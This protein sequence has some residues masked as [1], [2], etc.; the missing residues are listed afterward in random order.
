MS[1]D[2]HGTEPIRKDDSASTTEPKTSMGT[3]G[4]KVKN[5]VY[6]P[7]SNTTG[8]M[9]VDP[10]KS[11][12]KPQGANMQGSYN[13]KSPGTGT[14]RRGPAPSPDN[15]KIINGEYWHKHAGYPKSATTAAQGKLH[16]ASQKHHDEHNR[17]ITQ[18][19]HLNA[20]LGKDGLAGAPPLSAKDTIASAAGSVKRNIGSIAGTMALAGMDSFSGA[21]DS[22]FALNDALLSGKPLSIAG[23]LVGESVSR[24]SSI[25]TDYADARE[26]YRI[27]EDAPENVI[28]QTVLGRA[29]Q[30]ERESMNEAYGRE[31]RSTNSMLDVSNASNM[32]VTTGGRETAFKDTDY[33]KNNVSVGPEDWDEYARQVLKAKEDFVA[34]NG[35]DAWNDSMYKALENMTPDNASLFAG[36]MDRRMRDVDRAFN[37]L[38][39]NNR[40]YDLTDDGTGIDFSR[41]RDASTLSRGELDRYK[42]SL[43][44]AR[45]MSEE[46]L[47]TLRSRSKD[48]MVQ[49]RRQYTMERQAEQ[50]YN[51]RVKRLQEANTANNIMYGNADMRV[52]AEDIGLDADVDSRG[53][54]NSIQS[55]ERGIANMTSIL[56][57]QDLAISNAM[58]DGADMTDAIG[59]KLKYGIYSAKELDDLKNRIIPDWMDK[60]DRL[61]QGNADLKEEEARRNRAGMSPAEVLM[62][63]YDINPDTGLPNTVNSLQHYGEDLARNIGAWNKKNGITS[64]FLHDEAVKRIGTLVDP[65]KDPPEDVYAKLSS[66]PTNSP[67]YD[68]MMNLIRS[69][70]LPAGST[71]DT[72][73]FCGMHNMALATRMEQMLTNLQK[74]YNRSRSKGGAKMGSTEFDACMEELQ[75]QKNELTASCRALS[76]PS[77]SADPEK[78]GRTGLYNPALQQKLFDNI[79]RLAR[80]V[81]GK[82]SVTSSDLRSEDGAFYDDDVDS[83]QNYVY[84]TIRE[85]L[86]DPE[87]RERFKHGYPTDQLLMSLTDSTK[88]PE[89][90]RHIRNMMH[91]MSPVGV[92]D[93]D[94]MV[95]RYLAL[96]SLS[97]GRSSPYG[98][99]SEGTD[100]NISRLNHNLGKELEAY[101]M[102]VQSRGYDVTPAL[103]KKDALATAME[104]H[105][106]YVAKKLTIAE[107]RRDR[108]MSD[109]MR[110]ALDEYDADADESI[111]GLTNMTYNDVTGQF[112]MSRGGSLTRAAY[113]ADYYDPAVLKGY[114]DLTNASEPVRSTELGQRVSDLK[115]ELV[116]RAGYL[117]DAKTVASAVGSVTPDMV[118]SM[119]RIYPGAKGVTDQTFKDFF[120]DGAGIGADRFGFS[121]DNGMDQL[122]TM[123]LRDVA[124][125]TRFSELIDNTTARR[126]DYMIRKMDDKKEEYATSKD[127]TEEEKMAF[128][129]SCS[130]CQNIMSAAKWYRQACREIDESDIAMDPDKRVEFMGLMR[131]SFI[132][133]LQTTKQKMWTAEGDT[134]ITALKFGNMDKINSSSIA[135]QAFI[136]AVFGLNSRDES[137]SNPYT[138]A[139]MDYIGDYVRNEALIKKAGNPI[140]VLRNLFNQGEWAMSGRMETPGG[141]SREVDLAVFTMDSGLCNA[142][143]GHKMEELKDLRDKISDTQA[144]ISDPAT[145]PNDLPFLEQDNEAYRNLSATWAAEMAMP[146]EE[147]LILRGLANGGRS[148]AEGSIDQDLQSGMQGADFDVS[149]WAND[150]PE[151]YNYDKDDIT[152]AVSYQ[153]SGEGDERTFSRIICPVVKVRDASG[154]VGRYILYSEN[155]ADNTTRRIA[156]TL[157]IGRGDIRGMSGRAREPSTLRSDRYVVPSVPFKNSESS[158]SKSKPTTSDPS[159]YMRNG[160]RD[161]YEA[162]NA[163]VAGGTVLNGLLYPCGKVG[164]SMCYLVNRTLDSV[165]ING[166][167][168]TYVSRR[169]G[170]IR[171]DRLK[172]TLGGERVYV[173]LPWMDV[174]VKP[175]CMFFGLLDVYVPWA[176]DGFDDPRVQSESL[177]I[178]ASFDEA[179]SA[180]ALIRDFGGFDDT[181][182]IEGDPIAR[183]IRNVLMRAYA[184]VGAYSRTV[185]SQIRSKASGMPKLNLDNYYAILEAS[186]EL[187]KDVGI[188]ECSSHGAW[189]LIKGLK[190]NAMLALASNPYLQYLEQFKS[191][192]P[193]IDAMAY[194]GNGLGAE[195]REMHVKDMMLLIGFIK[196]CR[197][198]REL[199]MVPKFYEDVDDEWKDAA[200]YWYDILHHEG[201]EPATQL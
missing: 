151:L 97:S 41:F 6:D 67:E 126:L 175:P 186:A 134:P 102:Y 30:G 82:E 60:R 17:D 117:N 169:F 148:F 123:T 80:G 177:K 153:A 111:M 173:T 64:D 136:G 44:I 200:G 5:L 9:S 18:T 46:Q 14:G 160:I 4:S 172:Q 125:V 190:S 105:M 114:S 119:M 50:E 192:R 68:M 185:F 57:G 122:V 1:D 63:N 163:D 174:Y 35:Q 165:M 24:L 53:M 66:V 51:R 188:G 157:G 161:L 90:E 34:D 179:A 29:Y 56:N 108:D 55:L 65:K 19:L 199:F 45:K 7:V 150:V 109:G 171:C 116:S 21:L 70:S 187:A 33:W 49:N 76:E 11:S 37:E 22:V 74:D 16:R 149:Q 78:A 118:R 101:N 159:E 168:V 110:A 103:G 130:V 121:L 88:S 164:P 92:A 104:Q 27:P 94:N 15:I 100:E 155:P 96:A 182:L 132:D 25:A 91:S 43:Q 144:R 162:Y 156:D 87:S 198:T 154:K 81:S 8:S 139:Q 138:K 28:A 107:M 83:Y 124:G 20:G 115:D 98:W 40:V 93:Q 147:Y 95:N 2:D 195:E 196:A 84:D 120:S 48:A 194:I 176:K 32:V 85:K 184:Q 72:A 31:S 75:K 79:D 12:A 191:S 26:K 69:Q 99:S 128:K 61:K 145:D 131:E 181:S 13:P 113:L 129:A 183:G 86:N 133:A 158:I 142:S 39:E 170:D 141:A 166:S 180:V 178:A 127:L 112:D 201:D 143:M 135:A 152:L 3:G 38:M 137:N 52:L 71:A 77:K 47:K 10:Y 197:P 193:N 42:T 106:E 23:T 62:Q 73:H 189:H 146:A 58:S 167:R 89:L 140:K 59:L 36:A 54:P